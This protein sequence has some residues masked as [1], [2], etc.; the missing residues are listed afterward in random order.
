[1]D[2]LK[3]LRTAASRILRGQKRC[4]VCYWSFAA[5]ADAN[6]RRVVLN[7]RVAASAAAIL[8]ALAQRYHRPILTVNNAVG[9]VMNQSRRPGIPPLTSSASSAHTA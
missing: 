3:I 5:G 1:M 7:N 4:A 6:V 8:I 2:L 9:T